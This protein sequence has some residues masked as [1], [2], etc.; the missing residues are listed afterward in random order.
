MLRVFLVICVGAAVVGTIGDTSIEP[1]AATTAVDECAGQERVVFTGERFRFVP[2][3]FAMNPD[4]SVLT[5][6]SAD[7]PDATDGG[8]SFPVTS[9]DGRS[10]AW[11][12][13]LR[14]DAGPI[15]GSDNRVLVDDGESLGMHVWTTDSRSIVWDQGVPNR[16]I[17][18][19]DADGTNRSSPIPDLPSDYVSHGFPTTGP[20]GTITWVARHFGT[21]DE[22]ATGAVGTSGFTTVDIEGSFPVLA[23]GGDAVAT[24]SGDSI[25]VNRFDGNGFVEI[26]EVPGTN[27]FTGV[28]ELRW[29]P[30]GS[31]L[32]FTTAFDQVDANDELIFE[33]AVVDADG[34][35][36][37]RLTAGDGHD[38]AAPM[39]AP[40]GTR[41]LVRRTDTTS[42]DDDRI[43]IA[44]L[45]ADTG[46]VT[47]LD[48]GDI[49]FPRWPQW[50][51]GDVQCP[52]VDTP[53]TDVPATSF[54]VD[55][56]ACIFGLEVTNGTSGTTYSPADRVTREQMAAFL[57]RLWR[58][59]K[60]DCTEAVPTAFVDLAGSFAT[61]DVSCIFGL[62]VTNGTSATTYSPADFV[63]REQMAAF[64]ARLWRA[65]GG[66]CRAESTPIAD[67]V[68]SFA[69]DDVTCIYHLGV[70]TGTSETTYSPANFVT[71]EQMAAFLARFWRLAVAH[72]LKTTS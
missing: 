29:S 59:M 43:R 52:D 19:I 57:A 21:G 44:V 62:G 10:V 72:G 30:D 68:G 1:A 40:D 50:A 56:V 27:E 60:G 20:G 28:E 64:L 48:T 18:T 39:W 17:G 7:D 69:E 3:L 46:A 4:G 55:D 70:T 12:R 71:R 25:Y 41:L 42:N 65:A 67:T 2:E 47:E 38:Y 9:P 54:A 11:Q 16:T 35:D 32:V 22:F 36:L 61:A 45:D 14:I 53:F 8:V 34:G 24:R 63:T 5:G 26:I 33:V 58:G 37:R 51:C 15:T 23:P 6:I 13:G 49:A 66:P 31:R